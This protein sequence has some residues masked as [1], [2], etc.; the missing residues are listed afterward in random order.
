MMIYIDGRALDGVPEMLFK[1][2]TK[3]FRTWHARV[4]SLVSFLLD[5]NNI[6]R[7]PVTREKILAILC[8]KEAPERLD[9]PH[10]QHEVVLAAERK[11]RIDQIVARA[12]L[13]QLDLETIREEIQ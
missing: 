4:A 1:R 5:A 6:R 7:A 11:H 13:A 8:L 10:A 9:P 2:V 12:L 3:K